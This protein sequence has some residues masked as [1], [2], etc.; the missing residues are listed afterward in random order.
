M[1]C[2]DCDNCKLY[3][4]LVPVCFWDGGKEVNINDIACEAFVRKNEQ[5]KVGL[6]ENT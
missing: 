2:K 4:G 6:Y 5:G 1:T 3:H